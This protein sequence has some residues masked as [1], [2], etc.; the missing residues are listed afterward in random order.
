[1]KVLSHGIPFFCNEI[2]LRRYTGPHD[3]R[4]L[5]NWD[6][7][8]FRYNPLTE[9]APAV[10]ARIAENWKADL[11]LCWMPEVHP[12]PLGIEHCP[13]PTVA[14]VSDWNVFYPVLHRNLAR[15]DAV[16]CDT[17]GV[18][19]LT[20]EEVRPV[21]IFPLYSHIS[22]IH[23]AVPVD[24]DID[25]LFV[26]NLNHTAHMDRAR[27]LERI[28]QLSDTRRVVITT[29]V[30]D[31]AYG[32]LLSRAKIV[33]NHSIRG[34]LNLRVFETLACGALPF[35]ESSNVEVRQ[36]FTPGEDIVLYDEGNLELLIDRY[37][38]DWE[39]IGKPIAARAHARA[40]SW[41]GENRFTELIERT[42]SLP[43]GGR[44][45]LQFPVEEQAIQTLL[46]YGFS[47]WR[48][49]QSMEVGWVAKA[50]QLAP[51][52]PRAWTGAGQHLANAYSQAG[53]EEERR[54]RFCGAFMKAKQIAPES[55]VCALNAA[56]A[57]R[58]CGREADEARCL[59]DA[60]A[61]DGVTGWEFIVA[62]QSDPF[63]MRWHRAMAERTATPQMLH[64]EAH[65]RL[66]A[67][68]ARLENHGEAELHL[69]QVQALDAG[70]TGGVRLRA[71]MLWASGR[72]EEACAYL[73]D[74]L[75]DLP[76]EIDA[77]ERL[78]AMLNET[79]QREQ[80]RAL[81]QKAIRIARACNL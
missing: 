66:A 27:Y 29:G 7:A 52:D 26:G 58:A 37:L 17:R 10:I 3:L 6:G 56:A 43:S 45:F 22:T 50:V 78:I 8:D 12:P 49:Y 76:M 38:D 44:L 65:R 25:V 55:A 31:D 57:F 15:Y 41:A 13:I 60:L 61:V 71:E 59:H 1:M 54:T 70:N 46:M 5:G 51:C 23:R 47:R 73:S 20:S 19:A 68:H 62:P 16:V 21:H 35:L 24:R 81:A 75:A 36:W 74:H 67:L 30:F 79:G 34:E 40:Q 11:L 28:A 42:A 64:A 80:A 63:R 14:L 33:F 48:V 18:Q 2:P 53:S 69:D 39:G 77:Y 72:R 9:D 4:Y 32:E